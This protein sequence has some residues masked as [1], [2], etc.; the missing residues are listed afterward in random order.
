MSSLNPGYSSLAEETSRQAEVSY[1]PFASARR[2][3]LE[4]LVSNMSAEDLHF[5]LLLLFSFFLSPSADL[6][7]PACIRA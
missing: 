7:S 6:E 2:N 1:A 3:W 4:D 5:F